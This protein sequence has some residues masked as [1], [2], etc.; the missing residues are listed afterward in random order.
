MTYNVRRCLGLDGRLSPE[1]IAETIVEC[2]PDVIALQEL[3]VG[4]ARSL[5][6]DQAYEIAR[7]VGS[8]AVHFHP[9][10]SVMEEQYGDAILTSLPSRLIRAAALP[11][12]ARR[13]F[14]EPRGALWTA[15]QWRDVDLQV[16]NT[17]LGLGRRERW[18]QIQAL[19]GPHWLGSSDF[20]APAIL[21]GDF[22]SLPGGRVYKAALTKMRD[23][24]LMV[25]MPTPRPTFPSGLPLFR[26]DHIFI[27]ESI[28]VDCVEVWDT[29][30]ARVASDHRPLVARLRFDDSQ[31]FSPQPGGSSAPL[32]R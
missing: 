30:L 19:L 17:H 9:A 29:P 25:G 14:A 28:G 16:V 10:L 11:G 7:L 23:A 13:R 5:G 22:N 26:I 21:L 4:R 27:T 31:Q 32:D 2:D 1:R 6:V 15:V 24:Q 3:D 20:T 8:S 18:A 12:A